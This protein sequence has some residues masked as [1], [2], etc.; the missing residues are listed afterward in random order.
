MRLSFSE[1]S[2]LIVRVLTL[3]YKIPLYSPF[4]K[5]FRQKYFSQKISFHSH[6]DYA[7]RNAAKTSLQRTIFRS[8]I[9]KYAEK[10][11]NKNMSGFSFPAVSVEGGIL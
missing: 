4:V 6:R 1:F 3:E 8:P 11:Y 9:E 2:T 7:E 10:G 5:G